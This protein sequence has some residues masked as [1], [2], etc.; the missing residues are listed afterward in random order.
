VRAR[1]E[2]SGPTQAGEF[3]PAIAYKRLTAI[4][5]LTP[6]CS[7]IRCLGDVILPGPQSEMGSSCRRC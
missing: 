2:T 4:Q 3:P 6:Y 1:V 5:P 7:S